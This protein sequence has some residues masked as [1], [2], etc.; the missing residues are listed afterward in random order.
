MDGTD[1]PERGKQKQATPER[2]TR[3]ETIY[4]PATLDERTLEDIYEE[5]EQTMTATT[6]NLSMQ[7]AARDPSSEHN[8]DEASDN[9]RRYIKS[10]I[11]HR[12]KPRRGT[13]EARIHGTDHH[14]T[15]QATE[16]DRAQQHTH[17]N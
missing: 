1:S 16:R 11:Y 3:R 13:E 8:E 6:P 14:R 17:D 5:F 7:T 10:H 12:T 2:E 9:R 15:A 4:V